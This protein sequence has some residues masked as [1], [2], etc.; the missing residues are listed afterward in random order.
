MK[1]TKQ[2]L[3]IVLMVL[4]FGLALGCNSPEP[5]EETLIPMSPADPP[6]GYE[7]PHEQPEGTFEEGSP[8]LQPENREPAPDP[9]FETREDAPEQQELGSPGGY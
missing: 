3:F 4:A 8:G 9:P 7:Q 2:R 6:P 5:E 1:R